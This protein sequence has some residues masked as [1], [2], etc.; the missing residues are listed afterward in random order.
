MTHF[1]QK[2]WLGQNFSSPNMIYLVKNVER[3]LK[4]TKQTIKTILFSLPHS[5]VTKKKYF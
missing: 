5:S 2:V 1:Y 4:A 3:I